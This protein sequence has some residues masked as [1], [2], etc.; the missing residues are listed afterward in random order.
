MENKVTLYGSPSCG[1][2]IG[3]KSSL[4]RHGVD[5]EYKDIQKDP[6]ALETIV[7]WGY[8]SVPV[9]DAVIDGEAM[10]WSGMLPHNLERLLQLAK[11]ASLELAHE[12]EL[13]A[14]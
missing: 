2:C 1:G 9:I 12:H 4:K 3:I 11:Q 6:E 14:A 13:I 8:T 7:G 10:R 5:F